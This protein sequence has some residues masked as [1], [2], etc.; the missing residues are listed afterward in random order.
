MTKYL[1]AC[2]RACVCVKLQQYCQNNA[3]VYR[4][5]IPSIYFLPVLNSAKTPVRL[6]NGNDPRVGRLEVYHN[7]QWG[8][9]CDD[10]FD[11]LYVLIYQGLNMYQ[12]VW[13]SWFSHKDNARNLHDQ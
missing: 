10:S 12:Q 2:V 5:F 11:I 1:C 8:T 4:R 7:G 3:L 13:T 6:V 9:V